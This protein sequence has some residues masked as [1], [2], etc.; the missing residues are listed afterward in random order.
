MSAAKSKGNFRL[1]NIMNIIPRAIFFDLDETLV[2]N[3]IP[4]VALFGEMYHQFSSELGSDNQEAF[5]AA[6]RVHAKALWNTMFDHETSPE[7]QFIS[8]F[9]DAIIS[10]NAPIIKD[11]SILA[12][13]MFDRYK[14]LS[15]NNV[16]LHH[17]ALATLAS[18][19]QLGFITG[20][21]TNG[22]EE[23]QLGKIHVLELQDKVDHV[24][25]SAQAR[26]HKPNKEVFDLALSRAAIN[27]N[28]AW[29]IGDHPT[30]DV[31][32]AIRA[33]MRG[34]FYNPKQQAVETAFATLSERP[35][36]V[37]ESLAQVIG[38]VA[39]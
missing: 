35:D 9:K 29:Q 24:V 37:I 33:D 25:V 30:N 19:R 3:R 4:V 1:L 6:L 31:A 34:V 15:S 17:D 5:F 7:Q 11:P 28:Q 10:A 13:D 39:D 21:I 26:A 16:V 20:I 38:L 23:I 12:H 32:G 27:A 22:M 8:C 18:L 2:K 36:H 14:Q